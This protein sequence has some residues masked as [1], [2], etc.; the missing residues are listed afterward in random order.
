MKISRRC[1]IISLFVLILGSVCGLGFYSA[2]EAAM[3][4]LTKEAEPAPEL[5]VLWMNNGVTNETQRVI[6]VFGNPRS[7]I[8]VELGVREDGVIV[9][10]VAE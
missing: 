2:K 7:H 8:L 1:K 10:R 5:K 9:G 4:A 6:L 3:K